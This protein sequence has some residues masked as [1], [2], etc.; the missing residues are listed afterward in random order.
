[1]KVLV[2]CGALVVM[3]AGIGAGEMRVHSIEQADQLPVHCAPVGA[4]G[5]EAPALLIPT[6]PTERGT[7]VRVTTTEDS[8]N[9]DTSSFRALTANPGSDGVSLR[10][11]LTAA[12][13]ETGPVTVRFDPR[14]AGQVI[15]VGSSGGAALPRL[16]GNAAII[17]NGDVN[18]D[19]A[20]DVAISNAA[21][22]KFGLLVSGSGSTLHAL[23]IQGF[24]VGVF[25][26]A[27]GAATSYR[28]VTL[29]NLRV[30]GGSV[31]FGFT[32]GPPR[33]YEWRDILVVGNT[34]E[35]PPGEP[36]T[37][38]IFA[39]V[40]DKSN[41]LIERFTIAHNRVVLAGTR[42]E[43][44]TFGIAV[45]SGSGGGT[46]NTRVRDL[47]IAHNLV[48][49]HDAAGYG[50][51]VAAGDIGSAGNVM[52]NVRIV[53]NHVAATAG[54][55][56]LPVGIALS[57]GDAPAN[58]PDPGVTPVTYPDHNI[59][60]DVAVT[61]NYLDVGSGI[62]ALAGW[63]GGRRNAISTVAIAGNQIRIAPP[64]PR[65]TNGIRLTASAGGRPIDRPTGENEVANVVIESNSIDLQNPGAG[66]PSA[67]IAL[68]GGAEGGAMSRLQN[69]VV[70]RNLV[71]AGGVPGL[72]VMGGWN[73]AA[74]NVVSNV[75]IACNDVVGMPTL[76]APFFPGGLKGINL[77]GGFMN[78]TDNTVEDVRLANN[79][80]GGALGDYSSTDN[81]TGSSGNRVLIAGR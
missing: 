16:E 54:S 40:N 30:R 22:L 29:S 44:S 10:E 15:H 79:L 38:A 32:S 12:G 55:T 35:P 69:V 21:S 2:G 17:V 60:R 49:F 6:P 27:T 73:S 42:D 77:V 4:E 71:Q 51:R 36:N 19:N 63:G 37:M 80:V 78:A 75:D 7:V 46:S 45:V 5:Y 31:H 81:V 3:C 23:E 62:L 14:L 52:E 76:A 57:T 50:I 20:A 43:G 26:Q 33:I 25:V 58:Y 66:G 72:T 28:D 70:R 56:F 53:R 74:G 61:A 65:R 64:T 68:V 34:I 8:V 67:G 13:R 11:A 47:L 18:G 59:L 48:E 1:M 9:G 39:N 24:P 41:A